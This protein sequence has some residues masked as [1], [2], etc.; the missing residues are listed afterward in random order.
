M[1]GSEFDL[2]C[3][4]IEGTFTFGLPDEAVTAHATAVRRRCKMFLTTV[5]ADLSIPTAQY[6]YRCGQATQKLQHPAHAFQQWTVVLT[7]V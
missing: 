6:P 5:G 2:E 1:T 4:R 7:H 3:R